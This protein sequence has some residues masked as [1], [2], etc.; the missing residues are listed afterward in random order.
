MAD[1]AQPPVLI[2]HPNEGFRFWRIDEIY[3][4]GKDRGHVP[5]IDDLVLDWSS[6]F[7]RVT[8]VDLSSG[9]S[10]LAPWALPFSNDRVDDHDILLGRGPGTVTEHYRCYIDDSV[11]PHTLALDGVLHTYTTTASYMKIF[12]GTEIGDQ[13]QVISAFYDQQGN[14]MG[15][16]IP[17]QT[18]AM[19]DASNIA[20]KAPA[21]GATN[22]KLPDGELVTAVI[23]DDVGEP[24][25]KNVLIVKNTA[26]I[27]TTDASL[28]YITNIA[29]ETPFLSASDSTVIEYPV[30]MPVAGL[31]LVGVVTYSDG[32]QLRLPVDG[33][34]FSIYGL[35]NFV[36]TIQGQ[37]L[38]L[39]LN[40]RLSPDEYNY[41]A[42]PTPE[43]TIGRAYSATVKEHDGAYSVK[44]FGYPVWQD[45]LTGYRMEYF[46]YTLDRQDVYQVTN[47][48]QLTST[49]AGFNPLLYGVTQKISVAIDLNQVDPLFKSWR[50]VQTF[51]ITL[52]H[53]GDQDLGDA[54]TI[55]FSP[56]QDPPYGVGVRAQSHMVNQNLHQVDISCGA[57][58]LE[59]WL[60]RVFY[61]T[62]PL[63][64]PESEIR[65]PAPNFFVLHLTANVSL[66]VPISQWNQTIN[67]TQMPPAG[68]LI[69][70][71]FL[72][73]GAQTDLQLGTSA[74]IVHRT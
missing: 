26:F 12:R 23:Y 69:Y 42:E 35:D 72:R 39:V 10:K 29:L 59:E 32:S 43:R 74:M 4:V 6:G 53:R 22:L 54:W 34:K 11:T 51:E 61:A 48:V 56:N 45:L 28:K 27:R 52:R 47:L 41:I 67:A 62:Q 57:S 49:S 63:F 5:N 20:V 9:I 64:D 65:A 73:R 58:D 19:T 30:N 37:R 16:N 66:E 2:R 25:S 44:L 7:Y 24:I 38:D 31:N 1:P 8:D 36:A 17:L 60:D 15:E 40:Y 71:E 68:G 46:L 55:G 18:V 33:T 14:F 21:V 13:G 70:L 50:H 3:T